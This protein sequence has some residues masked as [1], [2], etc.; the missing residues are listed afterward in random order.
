MLLLPKPYPDEVVGSILARAVFHTGLPVKRL[1]WSIYGSR[2]SN[3]SFFLGSDIGRLAM[4]TGSSAVEFVLEHTMLPYAI[5]FLPPA[6]QARIIEK[7]ISLDTSSESLSSI[8]KSVTV[9]SRYRR[10][11]ASCVQEDLGL[12]GE[13][14]WRRAHLLPMSRACATHGIE[15]LETDIPV[16]GSWGTRNF[17]M[18][19]QA[20]ATRPCPP[21]AK[22]IERLVERVGLE[23]LHR[24]IPQN[25]NWSHVYK[26]RACELGYVMPS[27]DVASAA[28]ARG[29]ANE[30]GL[31][32]L[33]KH[34]AR[35]SSAATSS[36]PAL[37]VRP[38]SAPNVS[39]TRHV[40]MHAF[41]RLGVRAPE[42]VFQT[43]KRPGK[44]PRNL[45][46]TDEEAT[47]RFREFQEVWKQSS[48]RFTVRE[49]LEV[50][51]LAQTY[52][53]HYVEFPSLRAALRVFRYTDLA[54]RQIGRR[55]RV[56][57]SSAKRK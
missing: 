47:R 34:G 48:R 22:E 57:A 1:L 30:F 50:L 52:R 14:Y 33:V 20:K 7:A 36:W 11:C 56:Y 29:M 17:V 54:E 13:S 9:G 53:H 28:L 43:Y 35:F 10:I 37:L 16:G 51:G 26:L 21:V 27:G 42:Q 46:S 39:A 8:A 6:K 5:A 4:A 2:R 55:K 12:L 18:P 41:L 38:D 25:E 23:A 40:F 49:V 31:D 3:A 15:L 44:A 45:S 24:S 19:H 32:F